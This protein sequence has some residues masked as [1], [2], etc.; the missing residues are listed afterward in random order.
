MTNNFY[1]LEKILDKK[2]DAST[3]KSQYFGVVENFKISPKEIEDSIKDF[4]NQEDIEIIKNI[5]LSLKKNKK[6]P[7]TWTPQESFY[8]KNCKTI[9]SK[10]EYLIYR[11]KFKIYPEKKILSRFP[12][13]VLLEPTSICNLRCVMC[14]Q[15]DNKFTGDDV[16]K[17]S[18][19]Q[20]MGKMSL[21]LFK[22]IIDECESENAGA[23]SL[24]SRGEPMIN[25]KFSEMIDYLKNKNFFDIKI[26][27]NGSALTEKICHKILNN[28]INIL[29]IS[30]DANTSSLYKKIRVGG[31]FEKLLNNIEM[32][33]NIRKSSY[34]NSKLEIRISGVYFH[35]EQNEKDFYNFWKNKVDT[36]SYVKVQNRWDTYNNPVNKNKNNPCDFLWE[37]LYV[38]WDGT[39][40]P[41]DEDY[42]SLLSAGN[43]KNNTI[44]E[45]WNSEKLNKLR[46]LHLS[47]KRIEK[48]P[49]DRCGV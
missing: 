37:K 23:I 42:L 26:N 48:K 17:N 41:C 29:V 44:K 33:N 3:H 14:Y 20:L 15:M 18:N 24:G 46:E 31:N 34:I 19:K 12:T 49:C 36:V 40:N 9:K 1:N 35:P 7:F 39:T 43:V 25:N 2:Q 30:C 45:I 47:N 32:L 28:N 38:W 5:C 13:H 21:E 8:I 16:K 27:S 6:L 11:Y 22:K 10:I 4:K